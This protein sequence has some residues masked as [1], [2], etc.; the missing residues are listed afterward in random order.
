MAYCLKSI[1]RQGLY[2]YMKAVSSSSICSVKTKGSLSRMTIGQTAAA[3]KYGI[4][5]M[6]Y[7]LLESIPY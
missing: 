5:S 4:V 7:T 1:I 3:R 6:Y 2:T